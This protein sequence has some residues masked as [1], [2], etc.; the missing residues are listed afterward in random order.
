MTA[1]HD[2]QRRLGRYY[3]SEPP[4]RAPDWVL[5]S[6]LQTIESTRQRR[7]PVAPWRYTDLST[8]TKLAA[9]A[10]VV[11]AAGGFALWQL[12]PG[13]PGPS[14]ATTPSPTVAPSP[15]LAPTTRPGPTTYVPG[16]LTQTFTSNIHGFSLS[17]PEGWVAQAAT[18]P[19]TE[20]DPPFFGLPMGD[21]VHDEALRDHLFVG[22]VSQPLGATPLD[23]WLSGF[24][25]DEGCTMTAGAAI[26]GADRVLRSECDLA[27]ASSGGRGYL[28]VMNASGDDVELRTL[29]TAALFESILATMELQPE[30]AVDQ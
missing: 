25:A 3:D 4:Q 19:W 13:R 20:G 23:Q 27:L 14:P 16:A 5:Q 22:V 10:V 11:L 1:N 18:E 8:Y 15:T 9:A 26:D 2:L 17:Y 30:D 7:G 6:A 29:D 24:L 21:F 12:G 28:I